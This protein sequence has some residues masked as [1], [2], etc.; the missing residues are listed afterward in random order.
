MAE[1]SGNSILTCLGRLLVAMISAAIVSVCVLGAGLVYV[2][3]LPSESTWATNDRVLSV[4]PFAIG[5]YL[6]VFVIALVIVNVRKRGL[7]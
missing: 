4:I 5:T 1:R 7:K 3:S 6:V 2:N